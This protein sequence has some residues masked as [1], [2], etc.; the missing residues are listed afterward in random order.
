VNTVTADN[1]RRLWEILLKIRDEEKGEHNDYEVVISE[2][3]LV[4][5]ESKTGNSPL[6]I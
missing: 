2:S 3:G 4:R 6:A 1:A 5:T